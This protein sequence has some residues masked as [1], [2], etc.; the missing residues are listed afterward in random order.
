MSKAQPNQN[1]ILDL[2]FA[3]QHV[4]FVPREPEPWLV[5][6]DVCRVLDVSNPW[7]VLRDIPEKW[8][9]RAQIDRVCDLRNRRSHP[10]GSDALNSGVSS[11]RKSRARHTQTASIISPFGAM[12]LAFRSRKPEA[13]GFVEWL[14]EDVLAD[15][16]KYGVSVAGS[17]P[18]ERCKL[19]W[20]RLR[21]EREAEIAAANAS[22]EQTGLQTIAMF[23]AKNAVEPRGGLS[24]APR[25]APCAKE[26]GEGRVRSFTREGMR[27][28]YS[29]TVLH[30]AL[31]RLQPQL[32]W[33]AV[34]A[35]A[36]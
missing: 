21:I 9:G 4:R 11:P 20:H 36:A 6:A 26:Q 8:Q 27:R 3:G 7:R 14:F 17:T 33:P 15:F 19:L 25:A 13:E 2:L 31:A 23:R 32:P 28:A 1:P 16:L 18:A 24:H 12:F 10:V 30:A 29:D 34:G 22:L 5:H 35:S